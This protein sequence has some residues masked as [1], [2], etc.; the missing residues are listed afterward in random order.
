MNRTTGAF[1]NRGSYGS[2]WTSGANSGVYARYLRFYGAY[3]WPEYNAYKTGGFSVRC[4]AQ[5]KAWE[6]D[7]Y[8]VVLLQKIPFTFPSIFDIIQT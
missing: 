1:N 8:F 5:H 7:I 3:V 6:T 4:L 2:F